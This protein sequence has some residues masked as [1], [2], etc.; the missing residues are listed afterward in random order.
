[1]Y[2]AKSFMVVVAFVVF[3]FVMSITVLLVM[4]ATKGM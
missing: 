3:V 2:K 1:M 4:L